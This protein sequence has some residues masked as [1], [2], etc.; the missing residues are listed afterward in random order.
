MA[1]RTTSPVDTEVGGPIIADTTWAFTNSPYIV[2]A[3]VQVSAGVTLTIEPG[4]LVKFGR[5]RL[6]QVDGTLIARGTPDRSIIFSSSQSSP[7]LGDWGNI[8]F[9]AA[10]T[11][12]L[13][14]P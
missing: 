1:T 10:A 6:L 7:R 13:S 14:G 12:T 9:T 11:A 3:D 5:G 8:K 2:T 4:V